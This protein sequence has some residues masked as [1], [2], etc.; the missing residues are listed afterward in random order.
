M[1]EMTQ[2]S[3]TAA[4]VQAGKV[5]LKIGKLHNG[6]WTDMIWMC[7]SGGFT[8]G[9]DVFKWFKGYLIVGRKGTLVRLKEENFKDRVS[10]GLLV[11]TRHQF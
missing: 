11:F 3:G 8:V 5:V 4:A 1:T 7:K 9:I 10:Y 6:T 2:N